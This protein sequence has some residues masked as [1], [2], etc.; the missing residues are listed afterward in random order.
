MQSKPK[1]YRIIPKNVMHQATIAIH[2]KTC[3]TTVRNSAPIACT[4]VQVAAVYI[5]RGNTIDRY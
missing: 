3:G 1:Q 2:R 5:P 4:K